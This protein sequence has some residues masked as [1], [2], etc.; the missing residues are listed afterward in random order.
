MNLALS[1]YHCI[2]PKAL[3]EKFH[4]NGQG[5]IRLFCKVT[6]VKYLSFAGKGNISIYWPGDNVAFSHNHSWDTFRWPW[7]IFSSHWC[8][9]LVVG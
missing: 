4:W 7:P 6:E 2:V 8:H 5:V 9:I 3:K 1:V